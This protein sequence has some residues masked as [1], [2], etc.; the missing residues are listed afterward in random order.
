MSAR[1]VLTVCTVAAVAVLGPIAP[2][3]AGTV[4]VR[5]GVSAATYT[6]TDR[7]CTVSVPSGANGVAVLNAAKAKHCI[8]SYKLQSFPGLG[9]YVQCIDGLCAA[10]ASALFLTYWA[11]Y[12]NGVCSSYGIDHFSASPGKRLTFAY[13]TWVTYPRVTHC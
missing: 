4:S 9:H 6:P 7:A 10:P 1:S 3:H 12:V 2:A 13:T 11:M 8:V 5:F